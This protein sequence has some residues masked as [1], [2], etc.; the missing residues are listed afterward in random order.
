[1]SLIRRTIIISDLHIGGEYPILRDPGLLIDFLQCLAAYKPSKNEEVELVINGDFVDFLAEEPY[2][3]WTANETIAVEKFQ[4]VVRRQPELFKAFAVCAESLRRFTILMGNHDK[5]LAYPKVRDKLFETLHTEPHRCYFIQNN[6]CYRVGNLAIEH[7]NRYDSWNAVDYNGLREVISCASRGEAPPQQLAA[8]PGAHLVCDVINPIKKR[9]SFIDFLKPEDKV[10]T[11][12]LTTLEPSLLGDLP[13]L[14]RGARDFIQQVFRK[15]VW[16]LASIGLKS[17]KRRLVNISE[18]ED[19]LP[20]S[21]EAAFAEELKATKAAM[22]LRQVARYEPVPHFFGEPEPNSLKA[23]LENGKPI[24]AGRLRKLQVALEC[25]LANDK[26]FDIT[27]S[28]SS[29]SQPYVEAARQ[30]IEAGAAKVVIMGH[31]HLRR[32]I[33]ALSGGRYVNTGTW[34]R[35]IRMDSKYLEDSDTARGLFVGWLRELV[36]NELDTISEVV[37]TYADVRVVDGA[38]RDDNRP[39][40]RTHHKGESLT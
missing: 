17:G 23:L 3:A 15:A 5:E 14:F 19:S 28:E 8:C 2:E 33:P 9:Y 26:T 24:E 22:T 21:M 32:D 16:G 38:V 12:L 37:P 34:A 6:E 31:T 11:L 7:G 35:L 36:R 25:K 39:L 40:L 18:E 30:M 27:D 20:T 1:M 4:S 29:G 10:V 13:M